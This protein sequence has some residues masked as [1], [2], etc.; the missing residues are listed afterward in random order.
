MGLVSPFS[1]GITAGVGTVLV[2][3]SAGLPGANSSAAFNKG[4]LVG[5]SMRTQASVQT[6][7]FS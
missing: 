4:P 3:T 2:A 6:I 7:E 5:C 1:L